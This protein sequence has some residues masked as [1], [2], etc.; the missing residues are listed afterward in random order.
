MSGRWYC[1]SPMARAKTEK[2]IRSALS[3][4]NTGVGQDALAPV[5]A[6]Q[7]LPAAIETAQLDSPQGVVAGLPDQL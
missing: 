4:R 2:V 7:P 5:L 1:S 6:R 3:A